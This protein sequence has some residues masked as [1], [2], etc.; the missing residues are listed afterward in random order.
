MKGGKVGKKKDIKIS[1]LGLNL[2][3]NCDVFTWAWLLQVFISQ[4]QNIV[5]M[6]FDLG[7]VAFDNLTKMIIIIN[8]YGSVKS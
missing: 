6:D 7:E 5:L 8:H 4:N 1:G 3:R 2:L